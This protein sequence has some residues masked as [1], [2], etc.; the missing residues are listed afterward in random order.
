MDRSRVLVIDDEPQITRIIRRVLERTSRYEVRT[1]NEATRALAAAR[2]F[3]PDVIL[4][5]VVMPG[6]D[7]GEVAARI[8]Q[9]PRLS[10]VPVVFLTGIV[11]PDEIGAVG[12]DIAGRLFMAKPI[13]F[14][15]LIDRL[16]VLVA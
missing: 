11:S 10:E 12:R 9:D 16:D 1:E 3:R 7:G 8:Q 5:D 15:R 13:K 6:A 14:D 2:E 4:L